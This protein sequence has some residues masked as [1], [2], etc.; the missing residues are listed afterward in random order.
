MQYNKPIKNYLQ[1]IAVLFALLK[2]LHNFISEWNCLVL[3]FAAMRES[4]DWKNYATL[5]S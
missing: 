1:N 5:V 2:V 4:F 3:S